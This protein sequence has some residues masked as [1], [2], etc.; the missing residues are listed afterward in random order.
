MPYRFFSVPPHGGEAEAKLNQF[1][2]THRIT[3]VDRQFVSDGSTS[4]WALCVSYL[5]ASA[6]RAADE[7]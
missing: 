6:A 3:A 5:E 4:Y 7:A 2:S 1:L